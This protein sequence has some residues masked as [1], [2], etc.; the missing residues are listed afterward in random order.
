[1][2]AHVQL[3][4]HW[5]PRSFSAMVFSTPQHTSVPWVLPPH[6]QDFSVL[7]VKIAVLPVSPLLQPA[8]ASLDGST[9]I[10]CIKP[11]LSVSCHLQSCCEYTAS[12]SKSLTKMLNS[13]DTWG[14]LLVTSCLCATDPSETV[15]NPPALCLSSPYIN[16]LSL[17]I[18]CLT[19][20]KAFLKSMKKT[21]TALPLPTRPVTQGYQ[22]GQ[23]ELPFG[24]KRPLCT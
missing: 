12:S 1:M 14:T 10:L 3:E 19:V 23:A 9:T 2:L 7:Y 13:T 22:V 15:F 17:K 24:A 4:V 5:E 20:S 6:L 18:L 11:L 8:K 16:S 21:Y